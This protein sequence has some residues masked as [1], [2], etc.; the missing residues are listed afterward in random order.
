[1]TEWQKTAKKELVDLSGSAVSVFDRVIAKK[2]GEIELRYGNFYRHGRTPEKI[3]KSV[4]AILAAAGIPHRIVSTYEN[5]QPWPRDS[6]FQVVI[7]EAQS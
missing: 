1:M 3:A 6:Y 5:F 4:A 7:A 2:T